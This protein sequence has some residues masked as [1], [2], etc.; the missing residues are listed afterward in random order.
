MNQDELNNVVE[1]HKKYLGSKPDGVM[2]NLSGADLRGAD[3]RDADLSGANLRGADLRDADLSG[4]NLSGAYLSGAYLSGAYLPA[5]TMI[6]LANW[7]TLSDDLCRIAMRFDAANHADPTAFNRWKETGKCPYK[8]TKYQRCVNFNASC[9]LWNP[10]LL[11]VR[12]VSA[13]ELMVMLI[14]EKC[15]DSDYHDKGAK[16]A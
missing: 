2:A 6:L 8:E 5:P 14:R 1:L 9:D 10:E 13:Y 3:L 16:P 15:A 4:A 11:D 12:A 7:G